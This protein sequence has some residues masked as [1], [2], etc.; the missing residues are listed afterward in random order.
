MIGFRILPSILFAASIVSAQPVK[1]VWIQGTPRPGATAAA[2]KIRPDVHSVEFTDAEVIVR[3]AGISLANLGVL[4]ASPAPRNEPRQF[5]FRFPL[6]PRQ[7]TGVHAHV[8]AEYAGAFVNGVPIYNQFEAVSYRGQNLWHYDVIARGDDGTRTAAG[9]ARAELTHPGRTGLLES[10]IPESGQ[11]SPILGYAFDGFPI[12]GPW[13]STPEGLRRMRSSYRV[14]RIATRE[15]LPNGTLLAPGQEGP[16]VNEEYPIGSFVEDYEYV[17]GSGDLDQYN[18]RVTKTPNYPEGIYAY[19][20]TTSID[21]RLMFPYLLAHEYFGSYYYANKFAGA[22]QSRGEGVRIQFRAGGL[23]AAQSTLLQFQ[24]LDK[25]G[26]PIRYLE[27]VHE[28][29]IHLMIVS[30]DLQEFAHI[31]PEVNEFGVWE[32]NYTFLSGGKYML[33]ADFTAPGDNRRV[34]SFEVNVAGQPRPKSKLAVTS[35]TVKTSGGVPVTLETDGEIHALTEIELKFRLGDGKSTVAGLQPYLGAW[36]HA[37]IASEDLNRFD[38][39]HPLEDGSKIK[40]SEAH[41]H[42]PEALGPAPKQIRIPTS[43]LQGGL[44]KIWLQIQIAG[45]VETLPFVFKVAPPEPV[46]PKVLKLPP[47]GIRISVDPTGYDPAR[48]FIPENKP[49][50]LVFLRSAKANCGGKVVFPSLGITADIPYM[51]VAVVD[52]PPLPAGEIR[53]TC[54]M[55]MYRGSIVAVRLPDPEQ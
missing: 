55:G 43:F 5:T 16:P 45:K 17:A 15:K 3:S 13:G 24:I 9:R 51:G 48:I 49:V 14:R 54:G 21:G 50:S 38:H 8:P 1:S 42:T 23:T 11:H 40:R 53:F 19:F 35:T 22:M 25:P 31:H 30:Q 41:V 36:A 52:L 2:A 32:V 18:G 10:L 26:N 37:A 33:Y 39:A 7:E 34:E 29:P 44:F 20:L 12:Y 46:V 4:A 28:R 47:D 27:Y 6:Y